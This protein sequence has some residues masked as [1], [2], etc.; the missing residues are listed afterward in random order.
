[1][2]LIIKSLYVTLTFL[3]LVFTTGRVN[4]NTKKLT[5][6]N[7]ERRCTL[8]VYSNQSHRVVT[9]NLLAL[10]PYRARRGSSVPTAYKSEVGQDQQ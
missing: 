1:M 3:L 8:G 2:F 7:D 9:D 5:K 6:P 4:A 10:H